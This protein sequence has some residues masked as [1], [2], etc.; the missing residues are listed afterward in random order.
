MGANQVHVQWSQ[1]SNWQRSKTAS[2]LCVDSGRLLGFSEGA[3]DG[4]GQLWWDEEVGL[5]GGAV[6]YI[7][8][9]HQDHQL[10]RLVFQTPE[11]DTCR[12]GIWRVLSPA[13]LRCLRVPVEKQALLLQKA[14]RNN[15]S[16]SAQAVQAEVISIHFRLRACTRLWHRRTH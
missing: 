2:K 11:K 3:I 12:A 9:L 6:G 10:L 14:Q 15:W 16:V 13:S 4:E 7:W 5:D 1:I 8:F